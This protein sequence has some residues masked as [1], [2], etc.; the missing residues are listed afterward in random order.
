METKSAQA[1]AH[2]YRCASCGKTFAKSLKMLDFEHEPPKEIDVCPFCD[3][4]LTR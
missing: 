2:W 3:K 1:D 4:V